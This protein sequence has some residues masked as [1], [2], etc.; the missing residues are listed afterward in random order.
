[1]KE[2]PIPMGISRSPWNRMDPHPLGANV[3]DCPSTTAIVPVAIPAPSDASPPA[4]RGADLVYPSFPDHQ[5]QG[6]PGRAEEGEYGP[7]V[8]G[9]GGA[10]RA[11][12][13]CDAAGHREGQHQLTA[14]DP[15]PGEHPDQRHHE[16]W[17]DVDDHDRDLGTGNAHC[18]KETQQLDSEQWAADDAQPDSGLPGHARQSSGRPGQE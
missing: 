3:Q 7:P 4:A 10:A 13:E 12:D 2:Q 8:Q 15:V 5:I 1:M 14:V 9:D 11:G 18:R 17:V 16:Q 6:V